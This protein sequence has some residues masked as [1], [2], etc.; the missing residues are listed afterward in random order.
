MSS[1]AHTTAADEIP[2]VILPGPRRAHWCRMMADAVGKSP[3][4]DGDRDD[5]VAYW[6]RE[7]EI[8]EGATNG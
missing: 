8:A 6:I 7:A 5:D 1:D 2:A 3:T 4:Y